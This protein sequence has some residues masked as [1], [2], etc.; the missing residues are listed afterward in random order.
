MD[1]GCLGLS[2]YFEGMPGGLLNRSS[3]RQA[4]APG[5]AWASLTDKAGAVH[6]LVNGRLIASRAIPSGGQFK[7]LWR[8]DL[9]PNYSD[10]GSR[11]STESAYRLSFSSPTIANGHVHLSTLSDELRIY[12]WSLGAMSR[13]N[14]RYPAPPDRLLPGR[15]LLPGTE[16]AVPN[17]RFNLLLKSFKC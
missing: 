2:A 1:S 16:L 6:C 10:A 14:P 8:S 13:P 11:S 3:N 7:Q 12:G 4:E 5:I 9:W 17:G 15:G